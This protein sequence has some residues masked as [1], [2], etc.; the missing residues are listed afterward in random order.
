MSI[1][2]KAICCKGNKI[3]YVEGWYVNPDFQQK[4]IGLGLYIIAENWAIAPG[5]TEMASDT[6]Q[7]YPNSRRAHEAAGFNV[8]R[9]SIHFQKTIL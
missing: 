7:D 1:K 2:D 4:G 9:K 6:T 5:C 3:G 8:V